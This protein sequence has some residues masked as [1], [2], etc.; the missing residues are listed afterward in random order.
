MGTHTN[1]HG[2]SRF[3]EGFRYGDIRFSWEHYKVRSLYGREMRRESMLSFIHPTK[4]IQ[5]T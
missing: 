4:F 2:N 1:F 3:R 5:Y